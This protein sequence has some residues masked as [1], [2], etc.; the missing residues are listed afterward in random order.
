MQRLN[1]YKIYLDQDISLLK[2]KLT[3]ILIQ[4]HKMASFVMI[5]IIIHFNQIFK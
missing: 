2:V 1:N 5:I 3:A 4:L